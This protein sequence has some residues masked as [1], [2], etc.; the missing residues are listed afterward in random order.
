MDSCWSQSEAPLDKILN[1]VQSTTQAPRRSSQ[2]S[3]IRIFFCQCHAF[4]QHVN[5]LLKLCPLRKQ[6]IFYI[7]QIDP[8][9]KPALVVPPVITGGR[10]AVI[11][12]RSAAAPPRLPA[13]TKAENPTVL[14]GRPEREKQVHKVT[15]AEELW[16]IHDRRF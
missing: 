7:Y 9:P 13:K 16:E 11:C 10:C 6:T 15:A 14:E 12:H 2:Q 4:A 1:P 5:N 8:G 3:S